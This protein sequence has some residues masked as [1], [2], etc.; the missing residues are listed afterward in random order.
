MYARH[1]IQS[2]GNL[3]LT[4][5]GFEQFKQTLHNLD[6]QQQLLGQ[7]MH[8][9]REPGDDLDNTSYTEIR[10]R[11]V[12]VSSHMQTIRHIL[13]NATLI[14]RPKKPN[15]VELGNVIE[16]VSEHERRHYMLVGS[17]E[18][19]PSQYKI[20]DSSPVGQQLLGKQCGDYIEIGNGNKQTFQITAIR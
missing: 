18:A 13:R 20:S 4:P 5:S 7:E 9:V 15:V 8:E 2:N 6:K 11:A 19:D 1:S 17:L 12:E 14:A 16:L 3:Q 10:S